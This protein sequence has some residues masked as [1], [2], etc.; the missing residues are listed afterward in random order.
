MK[1]NTVTILFVLALSTLAWGSVSRAELLF[2]FGGLPTCDGKAEVRVPQIFQ[3]TF[4]RNTFYNSM[5][6]KVGLH[7]L[8]ALS[9]SRGVEM[10]EKDTALPTLS[11]MIRE[12]GC[13]TTTLSKNSDGSIM[14]E[15]KAKIVNSSVG[16]VVM[17]YVIF[18][19]KYDPNA[20]GLKLYSVEDTGGIAGFSFIFPVLS[21]GIPT[22][23]YDWIKKVN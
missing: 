1:N 18:R 4:Q 3:G 15:T 20:T 19:L 6:A 21:A 9:E 10:M 13:R 16:S 7:G 14:M 2:P 8:V 11:E 17:Q 22:D 12:H 23:D 5:T